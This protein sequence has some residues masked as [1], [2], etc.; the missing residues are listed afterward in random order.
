MDE[1]PAPVVNYVMCKRHANED[2]LEFGA[3]I[4]GMWLKH[5]QMGCI[6]ELCN[7]ALENPRSLLQPTDAEGSVISDLPE[8]EPQK[9]PTTD[10][11]LPEVE[12]SVTSPLSDGL[13]EGLDAQSASPCKDSGPGCS[14]SE[15]DGGSTSSTAAPPSARP[16]K[17]GS[18]VEES[19]EGGSWLER[20]HLLEHNIQQRLENLALNSLDVTHK[21]RSTVTAQ[22]GFDALEKSLRD[23]CAEQACTLAPHVEGLL[24]PG[25]EAEARV[26]I[27][28]Y[29][30]DMETEFEAILAAKT[31]NAEIMV[32]LR[33]QLQF[34]RRQA[35]TSAR[36]AMRRM[37]CANGRGHARRIGCLVLAELASCSAEDQLEA[38]HFRAIDAVA[39]LLQHCKEGEIDVHLTA[40]YAVKSFT[41]DALDEELRSELDSLL[42][43]IEASMLAE[44]G[45]RY[46]RAIYDIT[47]RALTDMSD[48]VVPDEAIARAKVE[49][50]QF[51]DATLSDMWFAWS[52]SSAR[53]NSR[54]SFI[55]DGCMAKVERQA[56]GFAHEMNRSAMNMLDRLLSDDSAGKV[57]QLVETR[58][59]EIA[60]EFA[61]IEV[62]AA[63]HLERL[64]DLT[65][66]IA[67]FCCSNMCSSSDE[68]SP[69]HLPDE[70]DSPTLQDQ[71]GSSAS[72]CTKDSKKRSRFTLKRIA[73][74]GRKALSSLRPGSHKAQPSQ[75]QQQVLEA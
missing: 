59:P 9:I 2:N 18:S 67:G 25:R 32:D 48:R 51:P 34:L 62:E 7:E 31:A 29:K 23:F 37:L 72:L 14:S 19:L 58:R 75:T 4:D 40:A 39:E 60:E 17:R 73:G 65:V 20:T 1:I 50:E 45:L 74:R 68:H 28:D 54:C 41:K 63:G 49:V 12:A 38:H 61:R 24:D 42:S 66:R 55:F 3:R 27:Q 21:S 5:A 10:V 36:R 57:K 6:V 26:A 35:W 69:L 16:E 71:E 46:E 43:C 70:V 44:M 11:N 64:R 8:A 52:G 47:H 22:G 53:E 56:N 33:E 30:L 15:E 13:P